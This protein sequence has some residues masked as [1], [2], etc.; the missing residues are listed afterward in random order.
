MW[1]MWTVYKD[2]A[3]PRQIRDFLQRHFEEVFEQNFV[4]SVESVDK[5][6]F[7]CPEEVIARPFQVVQSETHF[8]NKTV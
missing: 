1:T 5:A 4:D 3:K 6:V 7:I 2:P 8:V